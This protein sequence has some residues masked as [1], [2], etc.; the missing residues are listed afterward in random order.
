MMGTSC[1]V[2]KTTMNSNKPTT[3][4]AKTDDARVRPVVLKHLEQSITDN[5]RLGHLLAE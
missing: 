5:E 4:N 1:P 3:P 2:E